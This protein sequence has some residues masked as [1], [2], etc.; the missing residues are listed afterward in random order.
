MLTCANHAVEV[1]LEN[2]AGAVDQ[3]WIK[4]TSIH[5]ADP[6]VVDQQRHVAA[7]DCRRAHRCGIRYVQPDWQDAW[8]VDS[9]WVSYASVDLFRI[10]PEQLSG[11]SQAETAIG[12]S[13]EGN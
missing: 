6:G 13:D 3:S 5:A 4:R 7:T 11:K 9:I 12:P 1:G 2:L 10:T 8:Q